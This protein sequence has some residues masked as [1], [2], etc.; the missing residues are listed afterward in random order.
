MEKTMTASSTDSRR[1]NIKVWDST[2]E[3]LNLVRRHFG[4][5]QSAMI[6]EALSRV[7]A[8]EHLTYDELHKR[9]LSILHGGK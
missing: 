2:L 7:L 1:Q 4:K 8:E 6:D 3:R 5:T 9:K